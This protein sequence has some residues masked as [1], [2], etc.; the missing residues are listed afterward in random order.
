MAREIKKLKE[1]EKDSYIGSG[2]NWEN[3]VTNPI[4][5]KLRK[6]IKSAKKSRSSLEM[7]SVMKR[8]K[9]LRNVQ[10]HGMNLR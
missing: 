2:K 5:P 4:T 9:S 6:S 8:S 7:G 1:E 3:K 10:G